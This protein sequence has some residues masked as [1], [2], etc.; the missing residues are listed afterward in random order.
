MFG[1]KRVA[2]SRASGDSAVGV[3]PPQVWGRAADKLCMDISG[4]TNLASELSQ[5][6]TSQSAELLVLKKAMQVQEDSAKTLIESVTPATSL[7][8]HVGQNV[9]TIA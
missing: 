9:N 6:R 4:F 2:F 3:L 8:P 1:Y 7:P 5:Q